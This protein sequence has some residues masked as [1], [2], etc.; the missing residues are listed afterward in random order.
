MR[1]GHRPSADASPPR[2]GWSTGTG[3]GTE[4][5]PGDAAAMAM[6]ST[7]RT[8][9]G[10]WCRRRGFMET[11]AIKHT[12]ATGQYHSVTHRAAYSGLWGPTFASCGL[13]SNITS[14]PNSFHSIKGFCTTAAFC[15]T[16]PLT[17]Q[18][19]LSARS[20]WYQRLL[21]P[22]SGE[23]CV[24]E[25][26]HNVLQSVQVYKYKLNNKC[27]KNMLRLDRLHVVYDARGSSL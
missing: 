14:V 19:V 23:E 25:Y 27:N 26:I 3:Q 5:G 1:G 21:L 10:C 9:R 13:L 20:Q 18:T 12:G 7:E 6:A 4:A 11:T 16:P 24:T 2:H 17:C 15:I 8:L 22:S